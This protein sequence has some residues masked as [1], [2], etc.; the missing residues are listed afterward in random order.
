MSVEGNGTIVRFTGVN[1]QIVSGNGATDG[2]VNAL[3]N[4]IIGYNEQ[5]DPENERPPADR[6]GSHNIVVGAAH[7]Y[8]SFGGLVS[9]IDNSV[10]APYG[11]VVGG[12]TNSIGGVAAAVVG[13][14]CNGAGGEVST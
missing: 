7:G 9:G 1:V 6:T 8:S 3:G 11:A 2:P 10:S 14:E 13:G 12:R 5:R 4:L